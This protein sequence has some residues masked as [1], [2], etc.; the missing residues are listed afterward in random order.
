MNENPFPGDCMTLTHDTGNRQ[1]IDIDTGGGGGGVAGT[2]NDEIQEETG[3]NDI[4]RRKEREGEGTIERKRKT[5][6][7][8]EW[9]QKERQK[10]S[11]KRTEA[12]LE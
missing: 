4:Q 9:P 7:Q 12:K 10:E 6:R 1:G 2:K 8:R 11:K 5:A 3:A